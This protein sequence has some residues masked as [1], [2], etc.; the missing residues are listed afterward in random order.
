ME[1]DKW[2]LCKDEQPNK[3]GFYLV[4]QQHYD[5]STNSKKIGETEVDFAEFCFG[6]WR[7][8]RTIK[9][10]AWMPLPAPYK[11]DMRGGK[12]E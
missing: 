1:Q 8:A 10:I 4:T 7:R 3:N 11:E 12:N 9:V 5:L 6:E 2:I